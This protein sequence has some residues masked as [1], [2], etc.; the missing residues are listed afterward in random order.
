[1]EEILTLEELQRRFLLFLPQLIAA[2]VIFIVGIYL[3]NLA[4]K[5]VDRGL[6][7]RKAGE[8]ARL[9]VRQLTRWSLIVM[10]TITAL[11][12]VNFDLTAFVAGLG[13][14]GFTIG[15][16]LKDVG[17]NFV[18][19]LLLLLQKPFELGDVVEIDDFVGRVVDV[20]LR[21]TE[22][23]TNDGQNVILPNGLV[24]TSPILNYTRSPLSRIKLEVGV[25]YDSDLEQVR[26]V[27]LAAI[28]SV[29]QVLAEPAPFLTF[30]TFG[31]SAIAF[32][33]FY[34][35]RVDETS[36]FQ[37]S[38]LGVPTIKRAFDAAGIEIPFPIRTV[39]MAQ[40]SS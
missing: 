21:A 13:I 30:H 40:G 8:E 6:R 17:E 29:P 33:L 39:Y 20:N 10:V 34:W 36:Q 35:I 11:Q 5:L 31:D 3:A 4:A 32:N 15:F 28:A 1:M 24:Y 2:L 12:Q 9:V 38:D 16:A 27:A 22:M 37:A 14:V 19:G 18:A 25:G 23:L 7:R 26:E